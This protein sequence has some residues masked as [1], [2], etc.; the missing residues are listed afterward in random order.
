MT[1]PTSRQHNPKKPFKPTALRVPSLLATFA[2][3]IFLIGLLEYAAHKLPLTSKGHESLF[4]ESVSLV[5]KRNS[6]PESL[7]I[8]RSVSPVVDRMVALLRRVPGPETSIAES[9]AGSSVTTSTINNAKPST[10]SVANQ[11][12]TSAVHPSSN[13]RTI[14]TLSGTSTPTR[15]PAG[16]NPNLILPTVVT[17]DGWVHHH[18][19]RHPPQGALYKV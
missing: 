5:A 16:A 12:G 4:A 18:V 11:P 1:P 13:L 17:L 2:F 6:L 7:P 10:S 15:V 19:L 9:A 3:T 8:G 14:T